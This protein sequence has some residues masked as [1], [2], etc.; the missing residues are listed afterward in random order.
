[1]RATKIIVLL[2][3]FL[4]TCDRPSNL[5]STAP[6][7]YASV[8][9][10][11]PGSIENKA[12]WI[13]SLF[14]QMA[15]NNW[16]NGTVLYAEKGHLIYK[17]AFGYSNFK[18]RDSL[19][20]NSAF[21][22]ASVSKMI[23]AMSIMILKEREV[24][25]FDDTLQKF[26]PDFPYQGITIR[27]LLTHR[28]GLSRYMTLAHNKWHDKSIPLS[29]DDML[30]LFKKYKPGPYFSPDNGFHYCNTNY[31]LL[32]SVVEKATGKPFGEFVRENIFLPLGMHD[33]FVY[34]LEKETGIPAYPP[35]EVMGHKNYRWRPY[36]VHDD[37]L[38]GVTGD[39]GVYASVED[40]FR[41]DCALNDFTL[42]SEKTLQQAFMPGSPKYWRRNDNYG[43]GW[44]IKTQEDST[45]YH[46][47]W[48]K[49]FRA[50]YIRDMAQGKTLI[51][52]SNK[53]KGPG[54]AILWNIVGDTL[55]PIR[56]QTREAL[57]SRL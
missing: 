7:Q 21:Q 27:H 16:F 43:F 19:N 31:A 20:L 52:L 22:L 3:I 55:H 34:S 12:A 6:D 57:L 24:L 37:Y 48:W 47:G 51:V 26:I 23:T 53:E 33:S 54:S 2:L 49:G 13:D 10:P 40:L 25:D 14:S 18:T 32:A 36:P 15:C 39:K 5:A 1:M 17:N 46:F 11:E 8:T 56:F 44:R 4:I 35:L 9:V 45:V 28:S 50:Y 29:N 30:E 38:N 41:F 42:V